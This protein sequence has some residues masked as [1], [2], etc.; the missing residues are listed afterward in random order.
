MVSSSGILG[1]GFPE[2]SL[3][4]GLARKPHMIGVD[5]GSSD[6]GPH[7]LGS[8]KAF[9]NRL[10]IKR[11]LSLLVRGA[12]AN[13]IP[14]MIGTCGGAGGT[15]HLQMC[16]EILREIAREHDLHFKLALIH[17]EQRKSWLKDRLAAN[18]DRREKTDPD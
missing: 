1:Y 10:S 5:G 15:P 3:K 16:T 8:G 6:P 4:A 12:L 14:M 11:D 17:S 18:R 2:S 9:T 7:Y 13:E